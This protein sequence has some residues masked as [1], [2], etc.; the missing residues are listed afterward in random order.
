MVS[1]SMNIILQLLLTYFLVGMAL[2]QGTVDSCIYFYLRVNSIE[3]CLIVNF[4]TIPF[5]RISVQ[6]DE[7]FVQSLKRVFVGKGVA[8]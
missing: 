8:V 1:N 3:N 4:F 7:Q 2:G 6:M 5:Q